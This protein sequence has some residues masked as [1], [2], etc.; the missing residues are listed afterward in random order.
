MCVDK[1]ML[2]NFT[3]MRHTPRTKTKQ[4]QLTA[5]RR[6]QA[7]GGGH[8]LQQ[9]QP[10]NNSSHVRSMKEA[11]VSSPCCMCT[12]IAIGTELRLGCCWSS[13]NQ[14]G[15]GDYQMPLLPAPPLLLPPPR[16]P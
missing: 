16:P 9:Q 2:I 7:A 5:G 1:V 8:A 6:K 13:K 3:H 11:A 14:Q 4:P 12:A 15:V 10:N